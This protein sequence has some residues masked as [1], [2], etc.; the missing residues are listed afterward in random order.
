[1]PGSTHARAYLGRAYLGRAYLGR[2][3][4]V[5]GTNASAPHGQG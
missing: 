3:W 5:L 2:A 4:D 1:M